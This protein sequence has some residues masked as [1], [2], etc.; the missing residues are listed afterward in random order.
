MERELYATRNEIA[1]LAGNVD[2]LMV[3]L[4]SRNEAIEKH[5]KEQKSFDRQRDSII[6]D[7]FEQQAQKLHEHSERL[8]RHRLNIGN[9]RE[10]FVRATSPSD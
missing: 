6:D 9:H 3:Q 8:D 4:K 1:V 7:S 5:F 2:M 10:V